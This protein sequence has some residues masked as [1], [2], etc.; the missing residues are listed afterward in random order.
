LQAAKIIYEKDLE[1]GYGKVSLP[2]A[3][4]RKYPNAA[5]EWIWQYVFPSSKRSLDPI[6][7]QVK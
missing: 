2:Y 3:L 5:H 7:K 6:S 4:E 1:E